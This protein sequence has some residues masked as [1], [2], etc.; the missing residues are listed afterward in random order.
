MKIFVEDFFRTFAY[1]ALSGIFALIN[2]IIDIFQTL[3]KFIKNVVTPIFL[4]SLH[5]L[6]LFIA[7]FT[8]GLFDVLTNL[9][10]FISKLTLRLSK[11]F[12]KKSEFYINK[13]WE[14]Y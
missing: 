12:H 4:E 8:Q 6:K 7:I 13:Y 9:F 5:D 10:L 14:V 1:F 3:V 2:L 11:Y